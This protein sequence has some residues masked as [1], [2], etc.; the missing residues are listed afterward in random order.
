[1]NRRG[2]VIWALTCLCAVTGC[3]QESLP[4]V[5][6]PGGTFTR[7]VEGGTGFPKYD[8]LRFGADNPL[9]EVT[10]SSFRMSKY[11]VPFALYRE[12]A[13]PHWAKHGLTRLSWTD[14]EVLASAGIEDPSFQIPGDWPA[15][16]VGYFDA[17]EFCNWLSERDGF[18]PVYTLEEVRR[19]TADGSSTYLTL[20]VQW[21]EQ[22]NGYRL[23]TEA[24]WEYSA[25]AGNRDDAVVLS[26]EPAVIGRVA[27]YADNSGGTLQRIGQ[28]EPN[29]F[30]TH[31]MI[32]NIGEWTWDFYQPDYYPNSSD[33][34]P[35]GPEI[36]VWRWADYLPERTRVARGSVYRTP[37][38]LVA[39][40][41]RG[42][43]SPSYRGVIGIR[44]V[45]SVR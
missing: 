9:D 18:E 3:A 33:L 21:N 27:W 29:S 8:T 42:P 11:E 28:K 4:F 22:A 37:L 24:E 34:D 1:M 30:G 31:D 26:N 10:V 17:I 13:E 45:R 43:L 6:V 23:P 35:K 25:R 36:G 14:P 40:Y 2:A 7:G 38:D 5:E 39:P 12:F 19:Q 44:L 41:D 32:G 20:S 16:Y 15:F